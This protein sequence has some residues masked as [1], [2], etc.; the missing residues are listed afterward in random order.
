MSA[1]LDRQGLQVAAPID[2]RTKR[3]ESFS[4]QVIQGFWQKLEKKNPK[5][6]VMSPTFET[7]D[8]KKEEM[9]WQQFHLCIGVAE[10]RLLGGK[11]FLILRPESGNI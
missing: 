10:H 4:P 9:V 5:I 2:L 3:A 1:I 8:F 7:T 11:H 6:V